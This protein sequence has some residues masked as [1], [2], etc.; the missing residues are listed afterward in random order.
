M[1]ESEISLPHPFDARPAASTTKQKL[2]LDIEVANFMFVASSV[3]D[4]AIPFNSHTP[5]HRRHF[6]LNPPRTEFGKTLPPPGQI[7]NEGF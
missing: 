5:L 2:R 7:I 3:C 4:W 1:T 6:S